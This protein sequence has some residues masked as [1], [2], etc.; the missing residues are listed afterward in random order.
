MLSRRSQ[1]NAGL[2]V[3]VPLRA[4]LEDRLHDEAPPALPLDER[5]ALGRL[6]PA[7]GRLVEGEIERAEDAGGPAPASA[8]SRSSA[9]VRRAPAGSAP[10]VRSA[11]RA[12]RRGASAPQHRDRGLVGVVEQDVAVGARGEDRGLVVAADLG[13]QRV[14]AASASARACP[15]SASSGWMT[16]ARA[17]RKLVRSRIVTTPA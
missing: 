17:P 4:E 2:V 13:D 7:G 15:G 9:G 14:R 3:H 5:R 8:G 12:A 11:R 6:A 16:S 1:R 10:R